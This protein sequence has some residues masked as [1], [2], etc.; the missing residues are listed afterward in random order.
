MKG[1]PLNVSEAVRKRNPHLYGAGQL[2]AGQSEP[3]SP[4]PLVRRIENVAAGPA[5][6]AYRIQIT[7]RR[8]R[9]LDD[10]NLIA[11]I[12]PLRDAIAAT[13]GIDDGDPRLCFECGQVKSSATEDCVVS[14]FR[15]Q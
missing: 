10:D 14:I 8:K 5:G 6:V 12:K 9:L 11:S 1:V 15:R 13:L 2:E 4:P 7:A 3:A